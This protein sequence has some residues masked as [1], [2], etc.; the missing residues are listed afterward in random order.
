MKIG[1]PV[2][3]SVEQIDEFISNNELPSEIYQLR[4]QLQVIFE[5]NDGVLVKA[6]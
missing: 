6:M 3:S 4:N 5:W 2:D 1:L